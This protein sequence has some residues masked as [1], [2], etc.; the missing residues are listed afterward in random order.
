MESVGRELSVDVPHAK[1]KLGPRGRSGKNVKNAFWKLYLAKNLDQNF[2][3]FS[4]QNMARETPF[5]PKLEEKVLA[6]KKSYRP[7]KSKKWT[8]EIS[9]L[10]DENFDEAFLALLRAKSKF[11][12]TTNTPPGG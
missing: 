11:Y 2:F 1:K 4:S 8:L 5:E 7:L 9:Y 3:L 6:R 10:Y 12:L